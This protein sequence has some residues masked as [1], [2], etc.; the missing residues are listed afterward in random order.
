MKIYKVAFT[1][2]EL[3]RLPN[4]EQILFLQVGT[5]L[6]EINILHKVTYFSN[7][8][9]IGEIENKGQTTQST[10][11][12][13]ILIGKLW[14]AWETLS[15]SFFRTNLSNKF[16][17]KLDLEGQQSLQIIKKYFGKNEWISD[18]RN[19]FCFHYDRDEIANELRKMPEDEA[20]E[21]YLSEAQGNSLYYMSS[22]IQTLGIL[23]KVSDTNYK[24]ATDKLFKE[25]LEVTGAFIQFFNHLLAALVDDL[26]LTLEKIEIPD[27]PKISDIYI[28][29]F[30]MRE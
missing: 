15:T 13:S 7:K 12:L 2:K 20:L 8:K 21:F 28:P 22:S 3:E 6:N 11:F 19:R 26:S 14:E 17:E 5:I 27:P 16:E 9:G 23:R 1:K 30:I 29:Y 4:D 25:T 10:F 24:T 18:V